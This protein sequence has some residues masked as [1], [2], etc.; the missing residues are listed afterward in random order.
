MDKIWNFA[1][2]E[3]LNEKLWVISIPKF[4]Y[5]IRVQNIRKKTLPYFLFD[6]LFKCLYKTELPVC[7]FVYYMLFLMLEKRKKHQIP[8]NWSFKH[9]WIFLLVEEIKPASSAKEVSTL[10]QRAISSVPRKDI[11]NKIFILMLNNIKSDAFC[12]LPRVW[13]LQRNT[14]NLRKRNNNNNYQTW[15]GKE[16]KIS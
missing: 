14:Y 7:L 15:N 5:I 3:V 8:W 12:S 16:I 9:L 13:H 10:I 1:N 4:F 11:L 2:C 6:C